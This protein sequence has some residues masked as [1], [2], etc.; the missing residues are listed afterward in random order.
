M[1]DL[2]SETLI[3]L[4][5]ACRHPALRNKRTGRPCHVAQI[6]RHIQRGARAANGDRVQLE[7]IKA[8]SGWCTS[9]EAIERFIRTL[10]D[11]DLPLPTS[12]QRKRQ[13]AAA[14]KELAA[15]GFQIGGAE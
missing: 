2:N 13:Q 1:I 8:P 7:S 10:T 3:D 14:E 12:R 4:T 11:P 9:N 6:Y 5:T 15:A